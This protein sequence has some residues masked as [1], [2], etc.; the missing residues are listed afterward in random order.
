MKKYVSIFTFAAVAAATLVSCTK[1]IDNPKLVDNGIEM[2]TITVKTSIVD[3]KTTLDANHENIVWSAGDKISIFNDIDNT[4]AEVAY[5]DGGDITVSVPAATNE[6]YAHYPYFYGNT[7]GPESVSVYISNQQTQVNPGELNGEYFPMVAKGT[8]SPDNKALISFYPV[9]AALALNI[10]HTGLSG[11]EQVQKV[12]VTPSSTN[13]KFTG[14]QVTNLK[15]DNIKYTEAAYSNPVIVTLTNAL[16]LGDT[17]PTDKQTFEGQIYVCLAKQSYS[18]VKFEIETN[19]GIYTITSKNAA[20]DLVNNDFVPVNINLNKA[21]FVSFASAVNP[22]DYSWTLV[23]DALNIGEKVVIAASASDFALSTNQKSNNRGD[24]AI[25]KSGNAMTADVDVQVFEVVAGAKNNTFA[26]KCLNG[27][28]IGK[29]IAAASSGSNNMHSI[30]DLDD[31]ASWTV[32]ITSSTGVASVVAQGSYERNVLQYNSGSNLFSCYASTSQAAVVFY[33]V[34]LPPADLSFPNASYSVNLGETFTAPALTN[35]NSVTVTYSSSDTD[36][37]TVDASTGA[38][39]L[40][41]EGTT[42]IT[43]A[44]AGNDTYSATEASYELSVVDPNKVYYV[45]VTEAPTDWS[46]DYLIVYDNGTSSKV[47]TGVSSNL[48]QVA[49]VAITNSRIEASVYSSYNVVIAPGK[50]SGKYTMKMGNVFL[51]YTSTAASGSN[52][53]Y[54]VNSASSNGAEWTLSVDDAQNVYNTNRYLRYNTGSPRFC[55]YTSGQAKISFFKLEDNRPVVATPTFSV[56]AGEV[57][58]DTSVT[59]SC[60]TEGATI[61]YTTDGSDPTSNS[62]VYS[63]ALSITDDVT[64]KAIAVKEGCKDSVI[65]S[66]SYTVPV[67]ATPSISID[68]EGH[69]TITCTTDGAVIHYTT[70]SST[71]NGSSTTYT[72]SFSVSDGTTVKAIA[73]KSGSKDSAVADKTYSAG[74]GASVT[75]TF[76]A[77]DDKGSTTDQTADSI[78]KNG[79][80][81]S[82]TSAALG[83]TDNY[84]FYANSTTTISVSSGTITKVEFTNADGYAQTLL[85]VPSNGVGS[86]S[87]GIWTGSASSL[88]LKASAQYRATIIKVTY[89]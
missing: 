7:N 22:T 19:K 78:T 61:Y 15:G 12:T 3:T 32:S 20:F 72:S 68:D 70:D 23:K 51:A 11:T 38:I 60:A 58:V 46:G 82:C 16:T 29:Y 17:K 79:V 41:A 6:I 84:R 56:N 36:V 8:V 76:T 14:Q 66:A 44:F 42:T 81:I 75:V 33:R 88:T 39:T 59:I 52:Y 83:R 43:A 18:D 1:E 54:T 28:Q 21:S 64:I 86:Y 31:N 87:N 37:A 65:A 55:C 10:Y 5:V 2:K 89:Q 47:L 35:P 71:P 9:A 69:V 45:K 24:I 67:C 40:V 30:T 13:E 34:S 48:G 62:T 26:F 77:G 4:N 63:N 74:G 25:T 27:E 73:T 85:S 53:L 50:T 80:T 57:N 49:D